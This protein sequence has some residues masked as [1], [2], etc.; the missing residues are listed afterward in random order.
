[1]TSAA[2]GFVCVIDSAAPGWTATVNERAVPGQM[3]FG[4][5]KAVRI[6]AGDSRIAWK[7]D[8]W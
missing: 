6:E 8:P 7:Y 1:M 3:L 4:T 5:F 2:P